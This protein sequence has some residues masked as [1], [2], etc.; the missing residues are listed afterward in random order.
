M[1]DEADEEQDA[2]SW[3]TSRWEM[4]EA[5]RER[6]GNPGRVYENPEEEKAEQVRCAGAAAGMPASPWLPTSWASAGGMEWVCCRTTSGRSCGSAVPLKPAHDFSR[7]A[8]GKLLQGAGA[9]GRER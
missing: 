5:Y 2:W 8:L 4:A 7:Y 1:K 3:R 6:Q 9:D